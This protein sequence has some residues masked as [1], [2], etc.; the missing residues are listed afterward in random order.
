LFP[1]HGVQYELDAA[2]DFQFLKN[3]IQI[4]AD[5]VLDDMKNLGDFAILLSFRDEP[6]KPCSRVSVS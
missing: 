1:A 4:V 2:R 6:S 3:A 5:R